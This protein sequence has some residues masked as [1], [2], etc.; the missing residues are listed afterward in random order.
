MKTPQS[1]Q[2][3]FTHILFRKHQQIGKARA[4][5]PSAAKLIK[6]LRTKVREVDFSWESEDFVCLTKAEGKKEA[7]V[8]K[9]RRACR[10]NER[11]ETEM[12][13]WCR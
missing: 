10:R 5:S 12:E 3:Y 8:E 6:C 9:R 2:M 4:P 13:T 1:N 11:D 7:Q